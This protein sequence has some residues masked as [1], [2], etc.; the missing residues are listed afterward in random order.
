MANIIKY[1]ILSCCL[2]LLW[3]PLQA[4]VL[5]ATHRV[6]KAIS[7]DTLIISK[8]LMGEV[9]A[10][11]K[12][13][14]QP[15]DKKKQKKEEKKKEEKKQKKEEKKKEEKK[16]KKKKK[17]AKKDKAAIDWD[18]QF[19]DSMKKADKGFKDSDEAFNKV[20]QTKLA[21][22]EKDRK[23]FIKRLDDYV[24]NLVDPETLS[25]AKPFRRSKAPELHSV[26]V[27]NLDS[28]DHHFIPGAFNVPVQDQGRRGTCAAFTAIR[29]YETIAATFGKQVNLSEQYFYWSSKPDCQ[30]QACAKSG[31]WY[32]NGLDASKRARSYD[33]P[34]ESNCPY[35]KDKVSNNE[36]QIPLKRGCRSGVA[37]ALDFKRITIDQILGEI[38]NNHPVLAA[39]KLSP[40]FYRTRGVISHADAFKEG[41]KDAH[42]GGHAILLVGYIKLPKSYHAK[43]GAV[44]YIT[45]NSWSEGWGKGGYACLTQK[46]VDEFSLAHMSLSSIKI[47]PSVM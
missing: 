1:L 3:T 41:K 11:F 24:G 37:K 19:D 43:E 27:K 8:A 12:E 28:Y 30:Q 35:V 10:Y 20:Y 38:T 16:Q 29:A 15:D 18:K 46:W 17:P 21:K 32:G 25:P 42:A 13:D 5:T 22:W 9:K 7:Q 40:N 6:K 36:T 31:S 26:A 23:A 44:C 39:F 45:A 2:T 14:K 47:S 34:L 4:E 33:I